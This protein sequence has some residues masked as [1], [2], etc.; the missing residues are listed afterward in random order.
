MDL[1]QAAS[2]VR[3]RTKSVLVTQ[4][5]DGHPQLSNVMHHLGDD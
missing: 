1:D 4:R 2:Y 3:E 5:S